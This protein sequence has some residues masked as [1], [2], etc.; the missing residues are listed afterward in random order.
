MANVIEVT[1]R[2]IDEAS[3]IFNDA[4]QRAEEAM[5]TASSAVGGLSENVEGVPDVEVSTA[6][7]RQQL[8]AAEDAV[9][10]V[11]G[12]AENTRGFFDRLRDGAASAGEIVREHWG[13]IAAGAGVAGAALEGFSRKQ[14]ETNYAFE[15]MGRVTGQGSDEMRNMASEL[16]NVTFPMEDVTA[17][18]ETATQRGLEGEAIADYAN[19]WDM[20]GDATGEAGPELGKAGVAL[21]MVGITAGQ[22]GEALDAF[23]YITDNTTGSISE[24]LRFTERAGRELGDNTPH[25]NDMAGALAALEGKGYSA[26][27]AQRELQR[28]LRETDGDMEAAMETLGVSSEVYNEHRDAVEGS[29]IAI[30]ANAEAY[31]E[32]LTP[33]Q[34]LSAWG[35][36]LMVQFGGLADIAGIV[37]PAMMGLAA[38][39]SAVRGAMQLAGMAGGPIFLVIAGVAALAAGLVLAYKQSETFRNIVNAV[40][41]GVK[42]AF[43]AAWD[44]IQPVVDAIGAWFGETIPPILERAREIFANVWEVVSSALQTAW[45][46]MQPILATLRSWVEA[47]LVVAFKVLQAQVQV[48]WTLI[49]GAVQVAWSIL[50]GIF[51]TIVWVVE[52]ILAPVFTWLY[53][54]IVR[55]VWDW[56]SDKIVTA[57][58]NFIKPALDAIGRFI[59][60]T[61]APALQ[62]LWN[63]VVSPVWDWISDKIVTA[64]NKW[65][66]PAFDA[67][68]S[69]ISK[70][71]GPVIEW[72]WQNIVS[73][74]FTW[75]GKHISTAWNS[76]IKPIFT[77]LKNFIES[78]LGSTLR[79]LWDNVVKPVW[80]WIG[81]K[82]NTVWT[83]WVK[84][85]FDKMKSGVKS[86]G[87]RFD[88]A[89]KNIGKAWDKIKKIAAKPIHFVLDRVINRGLIS[90]FNKLVDWIPGVDGLKKVSIPGWLKNFGFASG[91][92]TGPGHKMQPAGVVHADEYVFNKEATN[93]F[94]RTIGLAGLDYMNRTGQFPGYDSG[95]LVKPVNG[96]LTSRF[97]RRWGGVHS[98][99]DWAV[100]TGT[101]VKAALAGRVARAQ[102]NAVTGRTGIGMLLSH[103]GNRNTYYGHLS[104]T[105]KKVGDVVKKGEVIARSGNTG[106][107][108]GPHLHFETWTGGKPV[109]PLT[110]MGGLPS[111]DSGGVDGGGGF[112]ILAPFRKIGE[113]ITGWFKS[114]FPDGGIFVDAA[115]QGA[116]GQFDKLVNFAKSKIPF[117]GD[118]EGGGGSSAAK[119]AVRSV[120]A[121]YGWDSGEQWAAIERIVQKE[122]SWNVNAA[123]PSSSARGLFQKMTSIHGPVAKTAAGQAEWG[124]KYIRDRYYSPRTALDFHNRNNY[125][126][127]GGILEPG[128]TVAKNMTGGPEAVLTR[129]QWATMMSLADYAG[130]AIVDSQATST[131]ASR[132]GDEPVTVIE[133]NEHNIT[134]NV[135]ARDLDEV[136]SIEQF[137]EMIKHERQM[138]RAHERGTKRSGKV[139]A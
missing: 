8:R 129:P 121:K 81:D 84:P 85:A 94:R 39:V 113:K 47:Y 97:G 28:G 36:N 105:L 51:N 56:I 13:K 54:N 23:G 32:S 125:Y 138:K 22:E 43:S 61:L 91:G 117:M 79:W 53:Q 132:G 103:P 41:E 19:F 89:V 55:P 100:P 70:G 126:D 127:D 66:K 99:V 136:R 64:W 128:L 5:S 48:A 63:K 102:W 109:N 90:G 16:Q 65:I 27:T 14:G 21:E 120:A 59:R 88:T 2:G 78:P 77:A 52:S 104:K 11:G 42:A 86:V 92:Y 38:G 29:G 6:T 60:D 98:G 12:E 62:W 110:Y 69:F 114:K 119:E 135:Y 26:R 24:F 108:T 58:N 87:D 116:K 46:F 101:A 9:R 131:G 18:M 124:L 31:K 73:P 123:N 30:E 33:M 45:E 57:W 96:Q 130:R 34:K 7:A 115:A 44:I 75:I 17:L 35:E 76:V 10:E 95:G 139:N 68:S 71:L 3:K 82:I 72:L 40:W 83:K 107:S 80:D 1:L 134:V 67:I 50:Q 15:R 20:V 137:I 122:S 118:D 4:G 111:S 25:V 106:K 112:D 49:S 74:V 37:A 133:Q 93:S